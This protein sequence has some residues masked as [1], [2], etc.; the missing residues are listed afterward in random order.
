MAPKVAQAMA[1][2]CVARPLNQFNVNQ[3]QYD[4]SDATAHD[5]AAA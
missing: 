1:G 2:R 5:R 3:M 4:Q